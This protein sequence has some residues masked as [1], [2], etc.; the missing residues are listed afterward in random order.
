MSVACDNCGKPARVHCDCF[1]AFCGKC[2]KLHHCGNE[3]LAQFS[4]GVADYSEQV[5]E[6]RIEPGDL[7]RALPMRPYQQEAYKGVL[8][9]FK[10]CDR[11]LVVM[12]TGCHRI[13]QLV[14][15]FRGRLRSV[16]FVQV[17][18]KLMGPDGTPRTVL[19]TIRGRG[20]MARINPTK[21]ESWVVNLDHVLSLVRTN[22]RTGRGGEI[23]D[24]TVR[25][26]ISWPKSRKHLYKLFRVPVRD[27]KG[28][29][30]LPLNPYFLGV[31]C[32]DGSLQ[33]TPSI[34][35]ADQ[36]IADDMI[37][38]A[39]NLGLKAR[40]ERAGG[41]SNTYLFS[42]KDGSKKWRA[43]YLRYVLGALDMQVPCGK[44]YIPHEFKIASF[45][46]RLQLLGG[47]MD[48]DGCVASGGYDYI[49]KSQQ[50]AEDVCFVARSVGLAAY[51][52]PCEKKSQ[53]G[54]WGVYFRVHISGDCSII[55]C[56]L[57][58]KSVPPRRQKKDVLRTGFTVEVL[59]DEEAYYGFTVDGDNR[60]LLDDFTVT[61][62][63]GKT[64]LFGHVA[65]NWDQGRVLIVAHRDELI[66]QAADKVGQIV[67]EQCDIEM[68]DDYADM[69]SLYRRSHVVVTSVQ[70]MS[71]QRRQNRF[72]PEDFGLMVIDEAHHA[73]ADSYRSV[74]DHFAKSG[75]LKV[76]GVTATPDRAD[77]A[78]LG[79]V[80]ET[81]AFDYQIND[82]I[83]DGWLSPIDQQYVFVEGLDF[84]NCRTTAGDLNGQD[85]ERIMTEEAMLH[86]VVDPAMQ[87]AAG[88]KT[89][90]FASSVAHADRM[91]EIANRHREGCA[92]FI[93]GKTPIEERREILK[94]YSAG[95]YQFLFNCAIA[96]EGFD[97]PSIG[98]VVVARPT[99][100][101]ALYAQMVGR[102]TRTLPGV[103][104]RWPDP[105]DRRRA[106]AESDKPNVLVVDFV[107]NS[108]KHKLIT[109]ADILGGNYDDEVIERAEKQ[110]KEKSKAGK[111]SDMLEEILAAQKAIEEEARR[112]RRQLIAKAQFGTKAVDPFAIY[113][114]APK[115]EPGWHKGRKPSEKMLNTLRKFGVD[116]RQLE[117]LSFTQAS[118][119]IGESIKRREK[120]LCTFKQAKTLAKNGFDTNVGFAEASRIIDALAKNGWKPL[121][122]QQTKE[123]VGA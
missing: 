34:T 109:T 68:G 25:E 28:G 48:T 118:Q 82:G 113:D 8:D 21:G 86:K 49:S 75:G 11:T 6:E 58:A 31:M 53:N 45:S 74:I 96:T 40:M 102:G 94:Q 37:A 47:L 63:C 87:L 57:T 22:D 90:V 71:R 117:Q 4:G 5:V 42:C 95:H 18:D 10:E 26:W 67:G 83:N 41:K 91:C 15:D 13:G 17:G 33:R 14:L 81:V 62:N 93:S 61:H 66:R 108:G 101:R 36:R 104:D 115:R 78:A 35:T 59:D 97:E 7:L 114:I 84:S 19:R 123:L 80:F 38:Y 55:P 65:A 103:I 20:K 44:K 16:E 92:A 119:L 56:R 69:G 60:Y 99:K 43:N 29:M 122:E 100:S 3:H 110:A 51:C 2:F 32:G 85:L 52:K 76:L 12:P 50:L 9:Q 89:L 24:V 106:I 23:V 111:S 120:K 27:F 112:K 54:T 70:T 39:A 64:V 72:K 105:E 79:K 46:D 98:C 30:R 77:E 107:G 116:D 1:A 121:S 73:V 88:R